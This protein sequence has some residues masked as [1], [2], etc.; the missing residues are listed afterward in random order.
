MSNCQYVILNDPFYNFTN[1]NIS[2]DLRTNDNDENGIIFR[3]DNSSAYPKFYVI[4]F[5]EDHPS[6]RNGPLPLEMPYFNWDTSADQIQPSKVTVHFVEGDVNGFNWYKIAETD[7]TRNNNQWYTWRV[8][9]NDTDIDLY[10]DNF[11]TPFMS[12]TDS[13]TSFGYFGFISFENEYANYD[14]LYVW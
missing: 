12:F 14:N 6:P 10:I 5:T 4:W 8:T 3:Y 7:W 9:A 1:G 13:R 2:C 11:N